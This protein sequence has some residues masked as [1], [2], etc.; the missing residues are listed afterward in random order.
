LESTAYAFFCFALSAKWAAQC[1]DG[2]ESI[3]ECEAKIERANTSKKKE[4]IQ[5]P[6]RMPI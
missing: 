6:S 1:L 5:I 2:A 3:A 4:S